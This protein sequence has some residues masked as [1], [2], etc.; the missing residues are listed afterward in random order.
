MDLKTEVYDTKSSFW[1]SVNQRIHSMS[2]EDP[3]HVLAIE[4]NGILKCVRR[5]RINVIKSMRNMVN[6]YEEKA[7][8]LIEVIRIEGEG[9]MK[10]FAP[11]FCSHYVELQHRI[12][13]LKHRFSPYI[14]YTVTPETVSVGDAISGEID[15]NDVNDN[16][17]SDAGSESGDENYSESSSIC[18]DKAS[19]SS[20]VSSEEESYSDESE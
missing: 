3:G 6:F 13:E 2:H 7:A 15:I 1:E 4:A 10:I 9:E 17:V 8:V 11:L 19:D 5:E 18:S 20:C 12:V 14:N 16:Y